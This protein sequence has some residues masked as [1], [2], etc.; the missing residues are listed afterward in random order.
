MAAGRVLLM[1]VADY[2]AFEATSAIK[3]EFVGGEVHAM[4]GASKEHNLIA[5]NIARSCAVV[6][7]RCS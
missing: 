5:L 1:S 7:A 3:H 4:S 6:R 2:L